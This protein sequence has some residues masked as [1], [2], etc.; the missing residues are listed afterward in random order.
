M[1]ILGLFDI[2][3]IDHYS[4][5]WLPLLVKN[6]ALLGIEHRELTERVKELEQRLD[7]TNETMMRFFRSLADI[8][9]TDG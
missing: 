2:K 6:N 9:K 3:L 8:K 1:K 4:T 5:H 7:E